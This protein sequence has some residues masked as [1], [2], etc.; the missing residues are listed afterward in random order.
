MVGA[1]LRSNTCYLI[2]LRHLIRWRA[3]AI[4]FFSLRKDLFSFMRAQHVT[5]YY[6]YHDSH[7]NLIN[8]A[9]EIFFFLTVPWYLYN[10]III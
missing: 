10:N 8:L 6:K 1:H 7:A 4:R 5:I 3:V 2:C 9:F